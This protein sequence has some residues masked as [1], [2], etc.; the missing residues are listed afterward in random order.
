MG[1]IPFHVFQSNNSCSLFG[2]HDDSKIPYLMA[3]FPIHLS[4]QP[5]D[6]ISLNGLPKSLRNREPHLSLLC[7]DEK[8]LKNIPSPTFPILKNVPKNFPLPNNLLLGKALVKM[9]IVTHR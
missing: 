9:N 2:H 3:P 4:H 1:E 5:L 7:L 8:K 6:P